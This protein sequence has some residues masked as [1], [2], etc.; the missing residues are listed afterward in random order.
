[1]SFALSIVP[2]DTCY[3][4]KDVY[5]CGHTAPRRGAG[6]LHRLG[7]YC[8]LCSALRDIGSNDLCVSPFAVERRIPHDCPACEKAAREEAAATLMSMRQQGDAQGQLREAQNLPSAANRTEEETLSR[9]SLR[10]KEYEAE[11]AESKRQDEVNNRGLDSLATTRIRQKIR[12]Y[13][14][15]WKLPA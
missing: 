15:Y 5:D 12:S 7:A 3:T 14:H 11:L 2:Q 6:R 1:M 9:H 8:L 4:L 10:L 13:K